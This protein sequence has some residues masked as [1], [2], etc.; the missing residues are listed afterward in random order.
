MKKYILKTL[1]VFFVILLVTSCNKEAEITKL[2]V[3]HFP[4]T[5][6][7]STN[8]VVLTDKTDSM[9]VLSFTWAAVSYGIKAPVTYTV[10]FD[11]P[12]DTTTTTPWSKAVEVP[13]GNDILTK[14]ILGI[15][16]NNIAINSLGL[17]SGEVSTM[18][19]RIKSFVDRPAF[20]NSLTFAITPYVKPVV[21]VGFPS[22]WVE[23]DFQGWSPAKAPTIVSVKSNTIYEGYI[24]IPSGGTNQFKLLSSPDLNHI[25]YGSGGTGL[26]STATSAG[27]LSVATDGYYELSCDL[28]TLKW[29][30]SKTTWSILGD[31]TPGA[32]TTDTEM[33][34]DP[35]NKV[36]TVTCNMILAGSFKFRANNAW[37]IDFGIDANGKLAYA[38][39]PVFGYVAG[40]NNLTVPSDGNYTITLDLHIPGQYTYKLKKN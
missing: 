22:L 18:V 30:A 40:L 13:V 5:L 14:A 9:Q 12:S 33:A 23:G 34:Y 29:T 37:T 2:T 3:I 15:D 19:A 10:Q 38:D 25:V 39:N 32:W 21:I 20:S 1:S 35:T 4:Q 17:N 7:G 27:N 36:W 6:T 11:V 16:L 8:S 28:S 26:L 31:A 24:Y